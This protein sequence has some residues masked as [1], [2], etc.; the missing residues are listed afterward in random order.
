MNLVNPDFEVA[1]PDFAHDS[2]NQRSKTRSKGK[3]HYVY[4]VMNQKIDG[5]KEEK[6]KKG[7]QNKK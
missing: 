2:W 6:T 1:I 3:A 7:K 5:K 4:F